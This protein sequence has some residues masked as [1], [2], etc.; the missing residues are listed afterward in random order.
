M[1]TSRKITSNFVKKEI[2][3]TFKKF[4]YLKPL[5][6][7]FLFFVG[8]GSII[9]VF[10]YKLENTVIGYISYFL[11]A[12]AFIVTCLKVPKIYKGAY[13][14]F[15]NIKFTNKLMHDVKYR[16]KVF[17]ISGLIFNSLYVLLKGTYS[18]VYSSIWMLFT[19]VYYLIITIIKFFLLKNLDKKHEK[20]QE[21][22]KYHQ[23]GHLLLILNI[24]MFIMITYTIIKEKSF[25]YP[26]MLIYASTFYAFYT[27][28]IAIINIFKYRK[29]HGLIF[30]AVKLLSLVSAIM[31]IY[32]A[33]TALLSTFGSDPKFA[34]LMN[35]LFGVIV[36]AFEL[37]VSLYMIIVP[38]KNN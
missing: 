2:L 27:L 30:S 34:F 1:L 21:I 19:A 36:I 37:A 17:L 32:I 31:S 12:Y 26:G 13:Q 11:S 18:I 23:V 6:F 14:H 10:I 20:K 35:T 7:W 4:F 38:C 25:T 8:F 5:M 3:D 29:N 15:D 33:Q 28:T 22:K 9:F 24:V 16:S